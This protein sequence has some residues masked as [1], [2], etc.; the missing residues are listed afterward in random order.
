MTDYTGPGPIKQIEEMH[1]KRHRALDALYD[2]MTVG[3]EYQDFTD[4]KLGMLI[5]VPGGTVKDY[6]HKF[7]ELGIL[8]RRMEYGTKTNGLVPGRHF[9]WTLLIPKDDAERLLTMTDEEEVKRFHEN[10]TNGLKLSADKRRGVPQKRQE[11]HPVAITT[12]SNATTT[13]VVRVENDQPVEAISGPDKPNPF[14]ALRPLR[15]DESYAMV[16]AA[17]Q[18]RDRSGKITE[19]IDALVTQA[20][21]LGMTIDEEAL[22]SSIVLDTD[23]RMEH[24]LLVMPYIESLERS[25]ERMT[26]IADQWKSKAEERDSL[27][28][29]V[30]RQKEQ[31]E[32]L[33]AQRVAN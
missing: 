14:S 24:I 12:G 1:A 19:R 4:S 29:Q 20:K 26:T 13:T 33:V 9:H 8:Q 5:D 27:A 15:K 7:G 2:L 30:K 32:R 11:D 6:T 10:Y 23:E 18:Y 17:R 25:L 21:E 16:E 22:R 28:L 31:I 3:E